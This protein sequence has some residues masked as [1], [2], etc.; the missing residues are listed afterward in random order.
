MEHISLWAMMTMLL[1]QTKTLNT[2]NRNKEVLL[3]SSK[4]V[5][6][7]VYTEKMWQGSNI[8]E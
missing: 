2:I 6:L 7:K 5:V 1:G 3:W 4:E 8:W